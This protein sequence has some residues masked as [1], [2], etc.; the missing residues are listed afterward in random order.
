MV[1]AN[2]KIERK[3]VK[4]EAYDIISK[5]I[6]RGELKPKT[7][8]RI[9]DLSESLGISRTPVREALLKLEDEGLVMTKAN[10][11]TM[12]SPINV[13]ETLDI[14][15]IISNLECLALRLGFE[16]INNEILEKLEKINEKIKLAKKD[17]NQLEALK[18][19]DKF[20]KIII[21][22][23]LNK[24]IYPLVQGLKRKVKRVEIY[25]FENDKDHLTTYEEHK[26][27]IAYMKDK[28]LDMSIKALRKN[29]VNTLDSVDEITE[30]NPLLED[31]IIEPTNL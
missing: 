30:E 11:W 3:F 7:R 5:K 25:F 22:M 21:D 24:E 4:D 15:P 10:R 1:L 13:K 14:Y 20:H 16:N 12:V 8:L 17:N 18:L 29:W 6:I 9:N 27:L 28:N 2:T 31:A 26:K 23:S 19:D